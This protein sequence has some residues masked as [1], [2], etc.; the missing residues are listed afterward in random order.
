MDQP[1]GLLQVSTQGLLSWVRVRVTSVPAD[2]AALLLQA[3]VEVNRSGT[4]L[5]SSSVALQRRGVRVVP[6]GP[7]ALVHQLHVAA[8]PARNLRHPDVGPGAADAAVSWLV[9]S[10]E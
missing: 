6:A 2:V 7:R 5:M 4:S 1:T 10:S 3:A 9:L 8:A